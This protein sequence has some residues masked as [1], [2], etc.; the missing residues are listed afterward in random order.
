[1]SDSGIWGPQP[2]KSAAVTH[3]P[4]KAVG[5]DSLS[6]AMK[7]LHSEHPH[8]VQGEGLQHRSTGKIHHNVT[9]NVYGANGGVK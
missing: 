5:T 9:S 2:P 1:M 8:H 7:Q 6:G 4:G 3:A